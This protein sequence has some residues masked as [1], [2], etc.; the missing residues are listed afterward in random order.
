MKLFEIIN[1]AEKKYNKHNPHN[2]SNEWSDFEEILRFI[3]FAKY[4]INYIDD[5]I[6]LLS[7]IIAI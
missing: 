7:Q 3:N 4:N 1:E 6:K 5:P 2:T